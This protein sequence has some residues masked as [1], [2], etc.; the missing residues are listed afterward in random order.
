MVSA[1]PWGGPLL[2]TDLADYVCGGPGADS[3]AALDGNDAVLAGG[4]DDTLDGGPGNDELRVGPG[5]D[6]IFGGSGNDL[7]VARDL[8]VDHV[9]CGEGYDVVVADPVDA[10]SV[11]CELRLARRR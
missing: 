4:G 5:F 3:I 6:S 11:D 7:L 8:V 1:G 9:E 2:G 10:V